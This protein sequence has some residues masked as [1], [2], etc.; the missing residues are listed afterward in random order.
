MPVNFL[1]LR[2]LGVDVLFLDYRKAFDSVAHKKLIEKLQLF[3]IQGNMLRWIEQFLVGRSMRVRVRGVYSALID[4]LSR[5]PQGSVLGPL[6][7]LLFVNDLPMFAD[8]TKLWIT[9]KS[10][11]DSAILQ[12]DLDNLIAWS[13]QWLLKFNPSKC[14]L[15]HIGHNLST[16]YHMVDDIG[17][18]VMIEETSLEKDLGIY[19]SSDLKPSTQCAKAA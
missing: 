11:T 3:G 10:K 17:K 2:L 12:N 16:E 8:D 1:R 14:K 7:F 15:M 6:L 13:N 4:V 5:V 18:N 19:V 9:L